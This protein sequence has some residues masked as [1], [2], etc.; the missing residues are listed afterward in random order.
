MEKI[1]ISDNS[2]SD[3]SFSVMF[4]LFVEQKIKDLDLRSFIKSEQAV[5]MGLEGEAN[6]IMRFSNMAQAKW[7]KLSWIIY[8]YRAKEFFGKVEKQ[9]N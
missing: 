7:V 6:P 1:L 2:I 3:F 9:K 8:D 4:D 5:G